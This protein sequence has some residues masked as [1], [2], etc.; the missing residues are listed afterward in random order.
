MKTLGMIGGLGPESTI[1]YYKFLIAEYRQRQHDGSYPSFFINS[2]NLTNV[3]DLVTANRL[4]E[5][6]EYL[7]AEVNKLASAGAEFGLIT[8]NTPHIVFDQIQQ[9]SRIPLI[10]IVE[11][12][13]QEA[14]SLGLNKLLLLGTRFTMQGRFYPDVFSK[15]GIQLIVPSADQRD[16]IHEKYMGELLKGIILPETRAGLLEIVD[17]LKQQEPIQGV[18]LAGTELPLILRGAGGDLPFLD[19]TEIHVRAAISRM[20]S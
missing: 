9:R 3:V 16:Y 11:A 18:I 15:A 1:E 19:T 7:S 13:C 17:R 2:V 8:A 12:T 5:V 6:A 20:L 14:Q 4:P 10:S